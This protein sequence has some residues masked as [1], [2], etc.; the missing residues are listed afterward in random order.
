MWSR[1]IIIAFDSDYNHFTLLSVAVVKKTTYLF[2]LE[3]EV[4]ERLSEGNKP[5]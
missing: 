2:L 4:C 1:D 5:F 3:K